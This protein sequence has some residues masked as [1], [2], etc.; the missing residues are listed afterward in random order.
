[1]QI[2]RLKKFILLIILIIVEKQKKYYINIESYY[3]KIK[4]KSFNSKLSKKNLVK[5]IGKN[6]NKRY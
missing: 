2:K 3:S 6:E 5:N 1:M 4:P